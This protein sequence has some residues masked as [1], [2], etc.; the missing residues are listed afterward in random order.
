MHKNIIFG[1]IKIHDINKFTKN[2]KYK[3]LLYN[4]EL[5]MERAYIEQ[6]NILQKYNF[7]SLYALYKSKEKILPSFR[8]NEIISADYNDGFI[9]IGYDKD[10]YDIVYT[11]FI[12]KISL[13][14]FVL[15]DLAIG[16]NY[17]GRNYC[18]KVINHIIKKCREFYKKGI[19]YSE[20]IPS[21]QIS[22]KCHMRA[23]FKKSA[24]QHNESTFIEYNRKF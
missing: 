17:R 9:A 16:Y 12:K 22:V 21:N 1:F 3:R 13:S 7:S 14:T 20:I 18:T 5:L 23:G 15:E 6:E 24:I 4:Y 10:T 11:G 19:I 2:N 8:I